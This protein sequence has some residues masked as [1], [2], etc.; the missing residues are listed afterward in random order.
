M[1]RVAL[2]TGANRGIGLEICRQLAAQGLT[3]LLTARDLT[4]GKA[5]AAELHRAG[6]EDV[7]VYQLEVTDGASVS[8]LRETVARD[9]GR[10]DVLVN[11]AG[12]YPD[13]IHRL[14][15]ADVELL[16]HAMD[17]NAYGPLRLIKAAVPLMK[18]HRWGRIV[19]VSS[20]IGELDDL[21][22][23]YPAYR[24]SKINLN[25]FTR[26]LA[27]EL[28]GH[29]IKVNA[30]CPGWV[31]TDMGGPGAPLSVTEGADTAVWL[32]TLPDDGPTG[33]FFRDRQQI[34]W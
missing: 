6:L 26:V 17:V 21:G 24:F 23:S 12:I 1:R 20:G 8:R 25:L 16:A 31:R 3:V 27:A 33:G 5:A 28:E 32:A 9:F 15:D 30:V 18:E 14:L 19:N 7:R 22:S 4:K 2:V 10:C 29:G 11:N 34:P 13:R